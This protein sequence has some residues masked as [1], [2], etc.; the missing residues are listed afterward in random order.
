[1][2]GHPPDE[3][4]SENWLVERLPALSA[5]L[6]RVIDLDAGLA[7]IRLND[8]HSD[9]VTAVGAA[10]DLEGG[11]AAILPTAQRNRPVAHE[12]VGTTRNVPLRV[13]ADDLASRPPHERL[14]ARIWV[15]RRRL[16]DVRTLSELRIRLNSTDFTETRTRD[17]ARTS[18]IDDQLARCDGPEPLPLLVR[19]RAAIRD[20]DRDLRFD[21]H[22]DLMLDHLLLFA[23][24]VELGL[25]PTESRRATRA[26]SDARDLAVTV[27]HGLLRS[28]DLAMRIARG[29][30][31]A[32]AREAL[33]TKLKE[34]VRLAQAAKY[35]E[36]EPL[37]RMRSALEASVDL[38]QAVAM[39]RSLDVVRGQVRD[40]ALARAQDLTPCLTSSVDL[41]RDA[42]IKHTAEHVRTFHDPLAQAMATALSHSLDVSA[43]RFGHELIHA[44]DRIEEAVTNLV[45]ADLAHVGLR[46]IPLEGLLWSPTTRWHTEW[47]ELV[48]S[49]SVKLRHNLYEIRRG[50]A[51][52]DGVV[53]DVT[54]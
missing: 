11:L 53:T 23:T 26:L 20:R 16:A 21:R 41:V 32:P 38:T 49:N 44:I 51:G 13:F 6:D 8:I 9:L 17:I 14:A 18:D 47:E 3:H 19:I 45:G 46:G 39:I 31:S 33:A 1:M 37:E 34:T 48:R 4:E 27:G 24:D 43:E 54:S 36:S 28:L 10:A 7:D 25:D 12:S 30:D 50:G 2:T 5:A 35:E 22:L 42:V 52:V 40:V 29:T 15:P